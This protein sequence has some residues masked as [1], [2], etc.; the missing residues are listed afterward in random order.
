MKKAGL[1]ILLC[2]FCMFVTG[3][4]SK[5]KFEGYGDLCGLVVDEN[6][7]PVSDFI[8]SCS[9]IKRPVVT[10]ESGLFVFYSL[11]S[12]EYTLSGKKL[13]YLQLKDVHYKFNDRS[14]ILVLQTKS[15]SAAILSA[16]EDLRLGQ[17]ESAKQLLDDIY[18]APGSQEDSY[19]RM[20]RFYTLPD[21]RNQQ[22]YYAKLKRKINV[23]ETF[24]NEYIKKM[25]EVIE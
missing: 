21:K 7:R 6:N 11:P 3:C 9:V 20:V 5:P 8:V 16:Q 18:Y 1:I 23:D 15:F 12:G 22:K 13:N 24:F 4:L 14:K 2:I 17:K 25:E 10:N 19:I